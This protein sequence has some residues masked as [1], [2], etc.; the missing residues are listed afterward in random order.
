MQWPKPF[1]QVK[2][3]TLFIDSVRW[4]RKGGKK[5]K[6]KENTKYKNI[7]EEISHA[8]T[9]VAV[10]QWQFIDTWNET[11]IVH[12]LDMHSFNAK[13]KE[14]KRIR[15]KIYIYVCVWKGINEPIQLLL[16]I[17]VT[18]KENVK[19]PDKSTWQYIHMFDYNFFDSCSFQLMLN[20]SNFTRRERAMWKKW[21]KWYYWRQKFKVLFT[22]TVGYCASENNLFYTL[23]N[24]IKY[25][26]IEIEDA[27]DNDN[28]IFELIGDIQN[29]FKI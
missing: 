20:I 13:K 8:M 23:S 21:R 4:G 2:L 10:H 14:K 26:T 22:S 28:R 11:V 17:L 24:K 3:H 27:T 29:I 7:Y 19:K 1:H 15:H 12:F 6:T 9:S 25:M 18:M 5:N 16:F